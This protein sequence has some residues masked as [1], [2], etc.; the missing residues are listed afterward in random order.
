MPERHGLEDQKG[1]EGVL[2]DGFLVLP[3]EQLVGSFLQ[4]QPEE[5]E[6]HSGSLVS[7]GCRLRLEGLKFGEVSPMLI[8][9]FQRCCEEAQLKHSKIQTSG[10]IFPLPEQP[11]GIKLAEDVQG[12][13]LAMCCAMNSYYGVLGSPKLIPSKVRTAALR[14]MVKYAETVCAWEEKF[15]GVSWEK[16]L[17]TRSVDYR[18]EEVKVARSFCWQNIEPALPQQVGSILLEDVCELGTLS[19][20]TNFEDYLLPLE[21]QVYTKPPKVMIEEGAWPQI[22]AGLISHGLCEIM[23]LREVYHLRGKPVLNGMFGVTKEEYCGKWEVYRLIMNLVPVNK[24][25][26]SLGG[27]VSTLP[28]WSGMT[29]YAMGGNEVTVMRGYPLLFLLVSNPCGMA[30]LYGFQSAGSG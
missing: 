15:L 8:T 19:Y 5:D 24:L 27:D 12:V 2:T 11:L 25:C 7:G 21:S 1:P 14:S 10:G 13:L 26:R 9:V 22:C 17:H 28:N 6:E 3:P 18:G 16:L 23:P 29:A 4:K 30:A 20:V